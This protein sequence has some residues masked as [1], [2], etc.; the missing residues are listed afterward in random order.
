MKTI[1]LSQGLEAI[2]D[3]EDFE[4]VSQFKW[5]ALRGSRTWYAR[6]NIQVNGKQTN[7]QLHR[8]I[9]DLK[10]DAP[11]VDHRD[12]LGLNCR[13][14]NLR[15]ASRQQNNANRRKLSPSSSWYKGVSKQ[16]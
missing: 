1:D 6:R 8:F 11:E 12:G 10:P 4:R 7:Q 2:V 16:K 14:D 13:R 3:D 9:L 15:L 5:T